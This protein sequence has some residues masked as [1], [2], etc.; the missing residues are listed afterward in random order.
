M[1]IFAQGGREQ[2]IRKVA[3]RALVTSVRGVLSV[4]FMYWSL[5]EDVAHDAISVS[6]QPYKGIPTAI[7]A[8]RKAQFQPGSSSNSIAAPASIAG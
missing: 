6:A 2:Q 4:S 1:Q 3:E 5:I 8:A 7:Y